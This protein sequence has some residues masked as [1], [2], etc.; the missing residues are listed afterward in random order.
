M[1]VFDC[2]IHVE[3]GLDTYNVPLTNANIIFNHVPSYKSHAN[4]F[5]TYSHSLIFDY[6]LN[7][8][9]VAEMTRS[10]KIKALK[11]HSRIQQIDDD[12]YSQV[13][14][15]LKKLD[16]NIPII[17]DAFYFGHE[18]AYQPSLPRLIE[19]ATRFPKSKFIVAH[20]GGH[21]VLDYFFHLRDLDNVGFDLSFSL[22]YLEGT[23]SFIDL[24]KLLKYTDS[25]KLFWGSD[26]PF[27]DPKIQFDNL[28]SIFSKLNY[29]SKRIEEICTQNWGEF[30]S[31]YDG[32]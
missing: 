17:Y 16:S 15:Y 7:F 1:E 23:S 25:R 5:A 6:K 28:M 9:F 19:L 10:K 26:F 29:G 30:C 27:A 8:D 24:E 2:H 12:E 3:N 18:L 20:A 11:I 22:Q 32:V 31:N 21:H 13:F 14:T 4:K